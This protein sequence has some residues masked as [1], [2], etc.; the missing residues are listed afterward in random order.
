MGEAIAVGDVLFKAN[1]ATGAVSGDFGLLYED[2]DVQA[3][4]VTDV[5][6]VI[7]GTVYENRIPAIAAYIKET[8]LPATI[9][10]SKSY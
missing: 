5:A 9:L 2:T 10:F 4:E 3:G 6:V 8:L 7:R 1:D